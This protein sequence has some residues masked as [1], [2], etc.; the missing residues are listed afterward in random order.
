VNALWENGEGEDKFLARERGGKKRRKEKGDGDS[1]PRR[2]NCMEKRKY[3][4]ERPRIYRSECGAEIMGARRLLR[5]SRRARKRTPLEGEDLRRSAEG[6]E[7]KIN[8]TSRGEI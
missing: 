8:L 4:A 3:Q 6:R 1:S 7:S 5:A 2:E